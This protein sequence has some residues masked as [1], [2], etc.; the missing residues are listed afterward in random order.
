M[1]GIASFYFAILQS[2]FSAI[3]PTLPAPPTPEQLQIVIIPELRLPRAWTWMHAIL[4]PR[5]VTHAPVATLVGSWFTICGR[6]IGRVYGAGQLRKLM[7]VVREHVGELGGE[8]TASRERTGMLIGDYLG[9]GHV[10]PP[11][12]KN[13]EV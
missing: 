1:N 9:Q 12:G 11:G 6:D 7:E 3:V 2:S 8:S 4:Q 5:M 13:W 10:P